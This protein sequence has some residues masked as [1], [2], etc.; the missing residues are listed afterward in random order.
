MQPWTRVSNDEL[1]LSDIPQEDADWGA[2]TDFALSIDGYA[3]DARLRYESSLWKIKM[4]FETGTAKLNSL[5]MT[6][7]RICL[8][9][10]Q[11]YLRRRLEECWSVGSFEGIEPDLS[12]AHALI[13]AI[14]EKLVPA[15]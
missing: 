11:R 6:E 7:L 12:Y 9:R 2:I 10:E 4:A 15:G 1:R 8:F 5:T 3:Q 13:R 14:R